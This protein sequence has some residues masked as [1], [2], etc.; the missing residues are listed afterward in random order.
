MEILK[1][2]QYNISISALLMVVFLLIWAG[3][4]LFRE[5]VMDFI[6]NFKEYRAICDKKSVIILFLWR[7][8]ICVLYLS[9][10]LLIVYKVIGF[11]LGL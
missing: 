4:K 2:I 5:L 11:I 9:C 8:S 10:S 3:T 7:L 1:I 6:I